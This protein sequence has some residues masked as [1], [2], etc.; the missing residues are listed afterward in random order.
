MRP[1]AA[2][3]SPPSLIRGLTLLATVALVV[4][5]MVGTSTYT[6]GAS[7]AAATGP[8]GILAWVVTATGYLFVA[9]VYA[10]LGVRYPVT[11]GA[12]AYARRA[13]GPFVGFQTVWAYW[14]SAVIGNAGIMT[15]VMGYAVGLWAPLER[16]TLL[17]FAVAQ[18]VLWGLCALNVRGVRH[19]ARLQ[20]AV[21]V[22][23][24]VPLLLVA[25]GLL[26]H[27]DAANLRPF[28]PKGYASLATGVALVVWAYSGVESATVPAEEVDRPER[29]IGLGT[30]LGYGVATLMFLA[31]A[32]GVA[33]SLP[34]DVVAQ[35]GR[36]VALAAATHLGPFP[37]LVIT[38]AAVVAGTGTLNGWILMAG[39]IPLTAAREGWFFPVFQKVHPRYG[40]PHVALVAGTAIS[41]VMLVMFFSRTLIGVFNFIALLSVLLTLLPHLLTTLADLVLA[42]RDPER[43]SP[44]ARRAALLTAPIAALFLCYAI[45]GVG[46]RA[47]LWGL[48]AMGMGLPLYAWFARTSGGAPVEMPTEA[49]L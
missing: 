5:N 28:A 34:N 11:G 33:G 40:T 7:L 3:V 16:S 26:A 45:Y 49:A 43:Y 42:R 2:G 37:A 20:V 4:G 36:P 35:S 10:R 21:M 12:Y 23:T 44:E 38:L 47:A 48:V 30:M 14:L 17:Q 22:L 29:T 15:A 8:L 39:R 31:A 13:F 27:F 18:G 6:L 24:A 46:L 41:S 1:P 25:I 19:S 9:L 32:V